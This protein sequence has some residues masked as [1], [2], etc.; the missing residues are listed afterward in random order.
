MMKEAV[1]RCASKEF[2]EAGQEKNPQTSTVVQDTENWQF[3]RKKRCLQLEHLPWAGLLTF[4]VRQ[5]L[6]MNEI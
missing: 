3:S 5:K 4:P 6:S 1:C 2:A